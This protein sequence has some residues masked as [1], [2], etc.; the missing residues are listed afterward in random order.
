MRMFPE[1][2]VRVKGESLTGLV[3]HGMSGRGTEGMALVVDTK[4]VLD[5]WPVGREILCEIN[6]LLA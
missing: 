2:N 6:P 5:A 4:R 3:L 1:T